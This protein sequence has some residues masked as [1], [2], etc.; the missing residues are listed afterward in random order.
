[1]PF[2]AYE[3]HEGRRK[4]AKIINQVR[5]SNA[6]TVLSDKNSAL[7]KGYISS[8]TGPLHCRRTLDQYSYYMLETTER[9]DKDQVVYRWAKSLGK[10]KKEVPILMVDQLWL[11]V[12]PD[13][14]VITSLPNTHQPSETY[15]IRKLLSEEIE[16]NKSRRAIQGPDSL[17]DVILKTCLN[18]MTREGPGGVKLQECFQSSINTIAESEAVTMKKLLK[19]ID[20]LAYADDPFALTAEIDSFSRISVES[21]Q[22]VEIIDIRDE[23]NI[24]KS[25]LTTQEKVLKEF[26][27]LIGSDEKATSS[28]DQAISRSKDA[29]SK[30]DG[31]WREQPT[32]VFNSSRFVD[33][34]IRIVEDNLNRVMEMNESAER[35]EAE[36]KQLLQFKQQQA[37]GWESRYAVKLSEQGKR[38]NTIMLVFTVVTIIFLPMSFIA[39]FFAIGIREFPKD[40]ESGEPN[41]P[42]HNVSEYLFGISIAISAVI[43][44]G[45]SLLFAR[46]ARKSRKRLE[47][48]KQQPPP[49]PGQLA[50]RAKLTTT[51]HRHAHKRDDS[52]LG[53]DCDSDLFVDEVKDA[54]GGGAGGDD[55]SESEASTADSDDGDDDNEYAQLFSRWRWHKHVPGIRWFW[56]WKLYEVRSVRRAGS[57]QQHRLR[58]G[59]EKWE[60]D[61]PLRRWRGRTYGAVGRFLAKWRSWTARLTLDGGGSEPGLKTYRQYVGED[62]ECQS[63]DERMRRD[64]KEMLHRERVQRRRTWI[65]GLFRL[66]HLDRTDDDDGPAV[67]TNDR[68]VSSW[69]ASFRKRRRRERDLEMGLEN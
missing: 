64:M 41:W 14:T 25:I 13:G 2:L 59:Q 58:K 10:P 15:N 42:I 18:I 34:A 22:L 52:T 36:L 21:A 12:L 54:R 51:K 44:I 17:V 69:M 67:A 7:I 57:R 1:M 24:I 26:Q 55:E 63:D 47:R 68:L 19:T 30:P 49:K 5:D 38:Q 43:L 29:R 61:Y 56:K 11:W 53:S 40:A 66:K 37:S 6:D 4:I 62:R 8:R 20:K 35:V 3:S 9:R 23:L 45:I 31:T 27:A 33:E 65:A 48:A 39:S 50:R 16:T 28:G 46:M 32:T 60:W